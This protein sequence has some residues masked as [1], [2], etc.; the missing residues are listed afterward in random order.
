[1]KR[2]T[3]KVNCWM[4]KS[5]LT[6]EPSSSVEAAF[7]LMHQNNCRHLLVTD[8]KKLIGVVSSAD[9][10]KDI[11]EGKGT[12]DSAMS[13]EMTTFKD[14]DAIIDVLRLFISKKLSVV[15]IVDE[16]G[17][18]VGVLSNHDLLVAFET[19]LLEKTT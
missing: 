16:D 2:D 4:S 11:Q 9:L 7:E 12:I 13:T 5:L 19:M 1:M 15:P 8:N 14:E 10:Y 17:S 3:S 6:V 18:L